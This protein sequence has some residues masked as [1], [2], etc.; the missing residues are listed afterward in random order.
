M[1]RAIYAYVVV[2]TAVVSIATGGEG[3]HLTR[4]SYSGAIPLEPSSVMR[5]ELGTSASVGIESGRNAKYYQI[6]W[7][8]NNEPLKGATESELRLTANDA[9]IAGTYHATLSTPCATVTTSTVRVELDQSGSNVVSRPSAVTDVAL[10]DIYPNPVSEKATI[11]FSIP[12]PTK[13]TLYI[14][15]LVGNTL[16]TIVNT[17]LPAGTHTVEHVVQNTSYASMMYNVI[18]EAP[19]YSIVKP[20]LVVK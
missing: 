16:S 2:F 1:T 17:T 6:Q 5:V 18:L 4:I 14:A 11:T 12:K 9:S 7:Y 20:M 3:P 13:V 19:G 15:D 10:E 8:R